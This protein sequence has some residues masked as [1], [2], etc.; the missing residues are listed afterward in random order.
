MGVRPIP[1]VLDVLADLLEHVRS[2]IRSQP[3]GCYLA[4]NGLNVCRRCLLLGE[5]K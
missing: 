3:C 2:L 1:E 5:K 4:D